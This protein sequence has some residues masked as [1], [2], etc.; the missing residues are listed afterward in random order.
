M[1]L[2]H[3]LEICIHSSVDRLHMESLRC[4]WIHLGSCV[5]ANL[6][7]PFILSQSYLVNGWAISLSHFLEICTHSSVDRLHMESFKCSWIHLGSCVRTNL[8]PFTLSQSY[9]V[10]GWAM[11]LSHFLEI[12]IHSSVD[13]LHM[14]S[15]RCSWIHLGSCVRTYLFLFT[16]HP[17]STLP[18]ERLSHEF[19]PLSRNLHTLLCRQIAPW[20]SIYVSKPIW[21]LC[22]ALPSSNKTQDWANLTLWKTDPILLSERLSQS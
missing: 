7:F 6:V 13:K 14:E 10:K 12:C 22:K 17:E 5:R 11:S 21:W 1:S 19:E 3:F 4:S 15:L 2:S 8:F 20:S 16:V 9:L 18:G